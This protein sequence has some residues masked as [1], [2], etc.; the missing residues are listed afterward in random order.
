MPEVPDEL[1]V[2]RVR[3]CEPTHFEWRDGYLTHNGGEKEVIA[4]LRIDWLSDLAFE[5]WLLTLT[6]N[7]KL[8]MKKTEYSRLKAKDWRVQRMLLLS[9]TAQQ[10]PVARE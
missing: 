9:D 6:S 5:I 2:N 10:S 3:I 1:E 4:L 7:Q 8:M